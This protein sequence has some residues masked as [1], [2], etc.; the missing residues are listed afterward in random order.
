M[1][2]WLILTI[3]FVGFLMFLI[4]IF[5]MD[6]VFKCRRSAKNNNLIAYL[7][8]FIVVKN[9]VHMNVIIIMDGILGVNK[10]HVVFANRFRDD[11]LYVSR[12]I[13]SISSFVL[14][15]Y[16]EN[17][18]YIFANKCLSDEN[19]SILYFIT[20]KAGS[21]TAK[22]MPKSLEKRMM[23]KINFSDKACLISL[24][25]R[26]IKSGGTESIED[27]FSDEEYC[28]FIKETEKN[29]EILKKLQDYIKTPNCAI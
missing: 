25:D 20:S 21:R 14:A 28:F 2:T 15:N 16:N 9:T 18:F 10:T 13:S 5:W 24:K 19:E 4:T 26:A 17:E 12:D 27:I 22:R 3:I 6:W 29:T 11:F 8:C 1:D 7:P 23:C